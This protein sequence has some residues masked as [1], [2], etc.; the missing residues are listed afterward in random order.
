M[1]YKFPTHNDQLM[2]LN[3]RDHISTRVLEDLQEQNHTKLG[4]DINVLSIKTSPMFRLAIT[5]V[6]YFAYTVF[7]FLLPWHEQYRVFILNFGRYPMTFAISHDQGLGAY[8]GEGL[9]G[10]LGHVSTVNVAWHAN[11]PYLLS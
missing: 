6:I 10:Y 2:M 4:V 1:T 7:G 8:L 5:M 9:V 3:I 11:I